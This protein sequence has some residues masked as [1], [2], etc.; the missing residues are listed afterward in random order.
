MSLDR[1]TIASR[2]STMALFQARQVRDRLA[3]W[4][5][6]TD[7]TIL[8]VSTEGDRWAGRLADLGGKGAFIK[9]VEHAILNG[10]ADLAVH[11]LKDMPADVP[12]TDGLTV[13]GYPARDDVNDV[14]VT[15]DGTRMHQLLPDTRVGT[16]GPRRVAQLA[17]YNPALVAIPVRGNVDSRLRLLKDREIDTLIV[18][19]CGLARLRS[20]DPRIG[21]GV[22]LETIS[23]V[24]MLPAV[25]AGLLALQTRTDDEETIAAVMRLCDPHAAAE[26]DAERTMLRALAGHCLAPIAGHADVVIRGRELRL[27]GAV[28]SPDGKTRLESTL[29]GPS[30]E[31][32]AAE[33][34]PTSSPRVPA[35]SWTTRADLRPCHTA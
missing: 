18:A 16:S 28:F 24:R 2:P 31:A 1:L 17:A 7:V 10:S 9:G 34:P 11:C 29:Q 35:E 27:T 3:H 13:V 32:V 33:W 23:T 25:G 26:A 21:E 14:M 6:D 4:Y 19:R 20:A 15:V 22:V 5:P 30:P 12:P 8:P